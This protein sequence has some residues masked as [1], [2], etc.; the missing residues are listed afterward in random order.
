MIFHV[1]NSAQ[2][3]QS[4]LLKKAMAILLAVLAVLIISSMVLDFCVLWVLTLITAMVY[5]ICSF[6]DAICLLYKKGKDLKNRISKSYT[7]IKDLMQTKR[8]TG[9]KGR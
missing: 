7:H 5:C 4:T 2:N 3:Q 1:K 9:R 6:L 8:K